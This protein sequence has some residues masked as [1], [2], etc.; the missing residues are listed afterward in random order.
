M[1]ILQAT[2]SQIEK[3]LD[4]NTE[5][6]VTYA[7]LECRLAIERICYERLRNAHDYISHDDLAK[8]QPRDIVR[9]LIQEVDATIAK[10]MKISISERPIAKDSP[11]LVCESFEPMKYHSLGTQKGFDSNELGKLWNGLANL[12]LHIKI[13]Q[14]KNSAVSQYG[15]IRAVT[16]KVRQAL[17][18]I[19]RISEGNLIMLFSMGD[20]ISF[21]CSCGSI[22]KRQ[23]PLLKDE[24][25][26][27]C[28]NPS[29]DESYVFVSV[30][31]SFV[32]RTFDIV[33]HVCGTSKSIPKRAVEKLPTDKQI[34]FSCTGCEE[35]ISVL[36]KAMQAQ[37]KKP[38]KEGR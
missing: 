15:D 35:P 22:N 6:S 19:R 28:I 31:N 1:R 27:N 11:P 20:V 9:T 2:I 24:Q 26:V 37:R 12:A 25:V 8:W 4:E 23:F 17:E 32:Q 34:F 36:W 29:C 33:C 13:P 7:A 3:L 21:E 30:E 18:E 38:P 14:S 10:P 5:A 16:V